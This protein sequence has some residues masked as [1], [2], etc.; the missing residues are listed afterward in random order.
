M[1]HTTKWKVT[2]LAVILAALFST[3]ALA[4]E[5]NTVD[6]SGA[7]STQ[8]EESASCFVCNV[9]GSA[10]LAYDSNLYD[11]DDY[12]SIRNFSWSGSLN[13]RLSENS[14]VFFSSGGYRA[15]EDE[16]GTYATDS[17]LGLSYSNLYQF[18][19]TGK[20]GVS[21][22]FTIP[23]SEISQDTELYTAFRL[24]VPVSFQVLGGDYSLT[25]RIRKNFYKYKTMNGRVL[26]EW[27]YSISA[28]GSYSFG[29][30]T[31]GASALG[32]N[33]MSFKGNRSRDFSY[34]ASAYAS[35]SI[36]KNW[37]TSFTVSTAGFYHDAEKGTLG[38][39]DLFD[40]DKA[41]Y[42]AD[43]TFSF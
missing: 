33:G 6:N 5:N 10:T 35:Y 4:D 25:P 3:S 14:Q 23:T 29:D 1:Q 37:S 43:I 11:K 39:I 36:T 18:G 22:Q 8:T 19:E 40:T 32:G 31:L 12:R 2:P 30:L 15:L 16:I 7:E 9:S 41:S 26:T 13:Y 42:I 24:S 21:G 17:V 38:N 27:V 34:G 28:N 20:V